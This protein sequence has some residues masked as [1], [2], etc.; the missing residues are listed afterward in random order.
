MANNLAT[1]RKALD[2]TQPEL[3]EKMGTTKNQL[4]KL[5]K[6]KRQLTQTWLEKAARATGVS[7][8]MFVKEGLQPEDVAAPH[9]AESKPADDL[10]SDFERI[11]PLLSEGRR[12]RL[13][14]DLL[15]AAR[16]EGVTEDAPAQSDSDAGKGQ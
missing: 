3:A 7:I 14:E 12:K 1:I 16:L 11:L 8:E 13:R 6:G 5:E 4:I 15:D 2:L 9:D 10:V